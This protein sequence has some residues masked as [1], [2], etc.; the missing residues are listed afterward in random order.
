MSNTA[1]VIV[2]LGVDRLEEV[3]AVS[4]AA[5]DPVYGEAWTK[6]Q[7]LAA[8]AMPGHRLRGVEVDGALA[9]FA[10]T[11]T[12]IDESELLLLAVTPKLRGNGLGRLLLEDWLGEAVSNG[13]HRAFLE[14]REDNPAVHLYRATGF[15]PVGLRKS[16]Y[17]GG[18]GVMRNAVSME[19][20]LC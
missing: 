5:F 15:I 2:G 16:Y 19:R 1:P 12:I 11:R 9:G 17:R 6:A 14:M 18:D 3:E 20:I 4:R 13:V 8:L 7:C 10:I